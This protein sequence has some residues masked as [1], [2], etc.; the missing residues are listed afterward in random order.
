MLKGLIRGND[1]H[2]NDEKSGSVI[3][4]DDIEVESFG[5]DWRDVDCYLSQSWKFWVWL[6]EMIVITYMDVTEVF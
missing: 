2:H 3:G 4:R 5:F 1:S 6:E